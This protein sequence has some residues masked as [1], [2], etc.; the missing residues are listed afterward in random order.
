MLLRFRIIFTNA[1]QEGVSRKNCVLYFKFS[2]CEKSV[3]QRQGEGGRCLLEYGAKNSGGEGGSGVEGSK[4]YFFV[5]KNS[6]GG[7]GLVG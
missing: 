2:T 6:G 3:W 7:E 4:K 1:W 5:I